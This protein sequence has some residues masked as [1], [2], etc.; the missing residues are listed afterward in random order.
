MKEESK[1]TKTKATASRSD[2]GKKQPQAKSNCSKG[3]QSK[4]S[5]TS[6]QSHK[7]EK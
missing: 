5:K 4:S 2:E 3:M 6:S 1:T 7:M